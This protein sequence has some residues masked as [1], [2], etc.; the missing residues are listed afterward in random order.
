MSNELL[1]RVETRI[2]EEKANIATFTKDER[3]AV[4]MTGKSKRENPG[5]VVNP[6]MYLKNINNV[7][8]ILK[9][10]ALG[11][12]LFPIRM[13]GSIF[14]FALAALF[15]RISVVGHDMTQPMGT[16]RRIMQYP[17]ALC[18][19]MIIFFCGVYWIETKGKK[20]KLSEAIAVVG[21]PHSTAIDAMIMM[22]LYNIP[23]AIG[24][25]E[26]LEV[27]LMGPIVKATQSVLVDRKDK[28][29]KEKAMQDI[30]AFLEHP[31]QKRHF[32]VFPEGT[33]TN[34]SVLINFKKGAFTPG[35]PVQV[36][37]F[38]IISSSIYSNK[39]NYYY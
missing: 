28:S 21:A 30:A 35:R 10:I 2:S 32:V 29:N 17:M 16:C 34:R 38:F 15:A 24:K 20:S 4:S 1:N 11:I 18:A 6:F 3:R 23:S 9:T 26:N 22:Y 36:F 31:K 33:C 27:P 12:T 8:E 19:R 5:P 39:T 13:L 37:F 7:Y 14:F 25:V